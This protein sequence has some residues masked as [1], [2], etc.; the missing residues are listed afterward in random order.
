MGHLQPS[1]SK[2]TL[3]VEALVGLTAIEYALVA[4]DLLG[5]VIERLNDPQSQLLALLI[6]RDRDVLDVA[7]YSQVVDAV[8]SIELASNIPP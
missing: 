6:L 5:D 2:S 4:A 8:L 1:P 7:N 3:Y